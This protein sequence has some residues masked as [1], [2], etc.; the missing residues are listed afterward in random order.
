MEE[1]KPKQDLEETSPKKISL[2]REVEVLK[3]DPLYLVKRNNIE[4]CFAES[5]Q[6]GILIIDSLAAKEMTMLSKDGTV[7]TY[8]QD[9]PEEDS[10]V[11]STMKDSGYIF[12]S[13]PEIAA[14]YHFLPVYGGSLVKTRLDISEPETEE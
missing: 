8:R 12:S 3:Y 4:V 2:S 5:K 1:S 7:K 6:D 10:I 11:I 13:V 9:L 14:I